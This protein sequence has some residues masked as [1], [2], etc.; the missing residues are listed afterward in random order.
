MYAEDF[1]SGGDVIVPPDSTPD[2]SHIGP[3]DG[4]YIQD[5]DADEAEQGAEEEMQPLGADTSFPAQEEPELPVDIPDPWEGPQTYAEDF[6]SGGDVRTMPG[7]RIDPAL[8]SGTSDLDDGIDAFL[9]PGAL[10]PNQSDERTSFGGEEEEEIFQPPPEHYVTAP[11]QRDRPIPADAEFITIDDSDEEQ[12]V[13]QPEAHKDFEQVGDKGL[14]DEE[15]EELQHEPSVMEYMREDQDEA[16]ISPPQTMFHEETEASAPILSLEQADE[17]PHVDLSVEE[18]QIFPE[19]SNT[20]EEQDEVISNVVDWNNP[21]AFPSGLPASASGHLATPSSE[22]EDQSPAAPEEETVNE[23][24]TV[25]DIEIGFTVEEHELLQHQAADVVHPAEVLEPNAVEDT[26]DDDGASEVVL[27]FEIHAHTTVFFEEEPMPAEY[28]TALPIKDEDIPR[29]DQMSVDEAQEETF[30]AETV[31]AATDEIADIEPKVIQPASEAILAQ[32]A[33]VPSGEILIPASTSD[34]EPRVEVGESA[35]LAENG[36]D[37]IGDDTQFTPGLEEMQEVQEVQQVQGDAVASSS[38]AQTHG[39]HQPPTHALGQLPTPPSDHVRY[40]SLPPMADEGEVAAVYSPPTKRG[41]EIEDVPDEDNDTAEQSVDLELTMDAERQAFLEYTVVEVVE[42]GDEDGYTDEDAD[43]EIDH[44]IEV[45]SVGSTSVTWER[46][47]DIDQGEYTVEE[48][49]TE[50]RL[51]EEPDDRAMSPGVVS[52]GP[53]EVAAL[54]ESRDGDL[55]IPDNVPFTES[56]TEAT[57]LEV[58]EEGSLP[59]D[60]FKEEPAPVAE[61]AQTE[62]RAEDTKIPAATVTAADDIAP[63]TEA[64]GLMP[65]T[66][67]ADMLDPT[68]HPLQ[69][70]PDLFLNLPGSPNRIL[71]PIGTPRPAGETIPVSVAITPSLLRTMRQQSH[72]PITPGTTQMQPQATSGL[73]PPASENLHSH[74][75]TSLARAFFGPSAAPDYFGNFGLS[76]GTSVPH[77]YSA[78]LTDLPQVPPQLRVDETPSI[79]QNFSSGSLAADVFGNVQN[80][81]V[82]ANAQ[83]RLPTSPIRFAPISSPPPPTNNQYPPI[84]MGVTLT[85]KPRIPILMADP[86]P[87]SLS[88]PSTSMVYVVHDEASEEDAG[89][90]N[91]MSSN[92]TL[93]KELE[94]KDT[95]SLLDDA[96]GLELQYPPEPQII[97]E[98]ENGML[99]RS[100]IQLTEVENVKRIA[101]NISTLPQLEN[102]VKSESSSRS[103]NSMD[104]Q[105]LDP[106]L[107]GKADGLNESTEGQLEKQSAN[108]LVTV[109][110]NPSTEPAK[111]LV[112]EASLAKTPGSKRAPKRKRN[113]SPGPDQ[114]SQ[115]ANKPSTSQKGKGK[116][117]SKSDRKRKSLDSKA[118]VLEPTSEETIHVRPRL[119]GAVDEHLQRAGSEKLSESSTATLTYRVLQ[120]ASRSPS[121]ASTAP[122]DKS[123]FIQPSPT[124]NKPNVPPIQPMPPTSLF[125]AHGQKRKQNLSNFPPKLTKQI[126]YRQP[127]PSLTP[128]V[129]RLPEQPAP[130]TTPVPDVIAPAAPVDAPP[131]A[132]TVAASTGPSVNSPIPAAP[133]VKFP[134]S[135]IPSIN[136]PAPTTKPTRTAS[137]TSS[138]VTRSH[139]RYHRISLP[140]EEGGPRACFLVPGCSLNDRELM[141]EE[142]I[143]DHG[144]ATQEDSYRMIKDIE[145]LNFEADLIGILRQ[146]VGLDILREQEVFYLPQ[147]G[148]EVVRKP[149]FRKSASE[150]SAMVRVPGESS[151][152]TSSPSY[153]GFIGSPGSYKAPASIADSNSTSLSGRRSFVDSE[154]GSSFVPTDTEAD[155]SDG[156]EPH[157]KRAR[158]SPEEKG[159]MGPPTQSKGK[160][161]SKSRRSKKVETT[162]NPDGE[163]EEAS[164]VEK[165][166]RKPRK[167][168]SKRGVKRSRTSEV[169]NAEDDS[170]RNPKKLKTHPTAPS[171]LS[172]EKPPPS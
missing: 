125:H 106:G 103:T 123:I 13:K 19:V 48:P 147:P 55:D 10:T 40:V 150:K 105:N 149:S 71:S 134:A 120:P 137:M 20:P 170:E 122:S 163:Q 1:Y 91:S 135:P 45:I 29:G 157:T 78:P 168:T 100:T 79:A 143:E 130:V 102:I 15:F 2:P 151:S 50:G 140:K 115:S 12:D 117:T 33:D 81:E 37:I 28:D 7:Q 86:Y 23:E 17:E 25:I 164:E 16:I 144:D 142:E 3:A 60:T 8:L 65:V 133:P 9:T 155:P 77:E 75:L 30:P 129:S 11:P 111:K 76:Q 165:P 46:E 72:Q 116:R 167:S 141:E 109:A 31:A 52:V 108:G 68:V 128:S 107:A 162:F 154:K 59:E 56:F 57:A 131:A 6:Y 97:A 84:S 114:P 158:P 96:E 83:I 92:S 51:T 39:H 166:S 22:G 89:L 69:S 156:D 24:T 160:S 70:N 63:T 73:S 66:T 90:D 5:L 85:R 41:V 62:E 95:A 126:Q 121:I 112:P 161:K 58:E 148:E 153:S 14:M 44:D 139:C 124:V 18:D 74:V 35:T 101:E 127:P 49:V 146:L 67:N 110:P 26:I 98:F 132:V 47:K 93:E 61:T 36:T 82:H 99:P 169:V 113:P 94:E 21:P 171:L 53:E 54:P 64:E 172:P 136:S 38:V 118:V 138:P 34:V 80:T 42:D 4:D 88:T 43:G 145:S 87:Y 119:K 159:T 152:Y 32:D 27:D 104:V